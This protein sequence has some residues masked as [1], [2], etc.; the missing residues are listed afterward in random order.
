MKKLILFAFVLLV[1]SSFGQTNEIIYSFQSF[2]NDFIKESTVSYYR[3]I[4]NRHAIGIRANFNWN[5]NNEH[6]YQT[7]FY[8]G[9]LDLIHRTNLLKNSKFRLL[10]EFGMSVKRIVQNDVSF[11]AYPTCFCELTIYNPTTFQINWL[12]TNYLGPTLGLGFDIQV[13]KFIRLGAT[14]NTKKYFIN[15]SNL[16]N[17]NDI[18]QKWESNFNLN[19]GL[20]F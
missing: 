9:Q 15:D 12:R 13:F 10:G 16:L 4:S 1:F 14:Y 11:I 17:I 20:N 8:E 6:Y 2:N 19:L 3:N 7:E 5:I 18:E